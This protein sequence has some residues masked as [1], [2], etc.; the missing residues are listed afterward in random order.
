MG[1]KYSV[2]QISVSECCTKC[3]IIKKKLFLVDKG[4]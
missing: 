3:C 2:L 1:A 4:W